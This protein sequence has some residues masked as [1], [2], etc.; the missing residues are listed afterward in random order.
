MEEEKIRYVFKDKSLGKGIS[1][2]VLLAY[3]LEKDIDVAAKHIPKNLV[4][5]Q[6]EME[7]FTNEV[8]ISTECDEFNNLIQ[9]FF[10]INEYPV[11]DNPLIFNYS[12]KLQINEI[13]SD[14][15]LN[16]YLPEFLEALCR[17]IDKASPIPYGEN[18]DDW[19]KEKRFNQPL[20]KIEI[21]RASCRER[22]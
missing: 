13:Y 18:N 20:I 12:I 3:D 5:D 7:L 14:K 15:H 4:N 16:M 17:A 21:G 22:V 6:K 9:S 1:G 10:D 8:L 19:S 11:R 2:E